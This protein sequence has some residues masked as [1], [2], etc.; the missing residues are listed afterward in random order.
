M[1]QLLNQASR[2][3]SIGIGCK[4]GVGVQAIIHLVEDAM[5]RIDGQAIALY[6]AAEKQTEPALGEAASRL[7]LP[8]VHLPRT[9]LE[10]VADQAVTRSPRVVELFNVP[11]IAETAALAGAGPG[12]RLLLP[13]IAAGGV[14]CA[15]AAKENP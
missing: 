9:A 3:L 14:T 2:S 8:L 12:S 15:I 10:A 7:G 13:R 5:S 11:S 4:S 1:N 6:T